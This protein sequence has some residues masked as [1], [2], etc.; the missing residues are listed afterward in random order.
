MVLE[1]PLKQAIRATLGTLHWAAP[2][3]CATDSLHMGTCAR[4][5]RSDNE[6]A[7][8]N[9]ITDNFLVTVGER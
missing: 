3:A 5:L 7:H 1:K 8:E 4:P 6:A 2:G 9:V